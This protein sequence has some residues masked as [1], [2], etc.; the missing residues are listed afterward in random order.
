MVQAMRVHF[1][2]AVNSAKISKSNGMY[3]IRDV[4]PIVDDIT[5]NSIL[6]PAAEV[7]KAYPSLND[8][9]APV[10]HPKNADG[11]YVS[12]ANATA[13][14]QYWVGAAV[15]NARKE[16]DAV[17]VDITVNEAQAQAMD[18]GRRLIERLDAAMAGNAGEPI[19]VSTGVLLRK[20]AAKGE[21]KGKAYN[22][23]ASDMVF[24]HLAILLDE[25]GAGTPEEGVGMWLNHEGA[26]EPVFMVNLEVKDVKQKPA[27][28]L[29]V[30][31]NDSLS[32][33][34]IER[35]IDEVLRET[36]PQP[37]G[38]DYGVYS[39]EIYDKSVVFRIGDSLYKSDY[40]IDSENVVSLVGE[41]TKV[42]R[43]IEYV[44]VNNREDA[45]TMKD[46]IVAA[47][48]AAGINSA[49][50]TDNDIL[51]AYNALQRKELE[52]QVNTLTEKIVS[53]EANEAKRI[54]GEK[55]AIADKLAVNSALTADDLMALPLQRLQELSAVNAAAPVVVGNASQQPQS[56]FA[57]Y[58]INNPFG[59]TK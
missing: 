34:D 11:Q 19:H 51:A 1:V 37:Q 30:N 18:N 22:A 3:T 33:R 43:R 27:Q 15:T 52:Q 55:K 40:N 28:D 42:E 8:T 14:Q 6:Y 56:E 7:N 45:P 20:T 47:L 10:G 53:M 32:F 46:T 4:V 50:M 21:S 39:I 5:L 49:G 13:M 31:S 24:D 36:F 26:E 48:N 25:Q 23:I 29:R 35:R 9:P 57:G 41:P 58:D 12:A 59:S 2:S 16:G 54:E 44:P 38:S 17:L